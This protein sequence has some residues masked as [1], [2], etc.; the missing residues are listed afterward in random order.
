MKSNGTD[1]SA[2]LASERKRPPGRL[3][4][5]GYGNPLRGDDGVG[6]RIADQLAK[7]AGDSATVL[8]VHQLTPEL[9]EPISSADLVVFID[10]CCEGQPGT[11]TC[12]TIQPD[13][14]L[15]QTFTHYFTPANLLSYAQATVSVSPKALLIS[16]AGRSFNCGEELTPAVATIVPEIVASVSE[17]W[18]AN[19]LAS[20][21]PAPGTGS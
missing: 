4:V 11:W 13:P 19:T 9:A 6:W 2:A 21:P 17:W 20:A 7:L 14:S 10:A 15:S 3:L 18:N 1:I 8:T 5:I 12:E 16:V